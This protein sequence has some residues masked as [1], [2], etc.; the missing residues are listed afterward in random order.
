MTCLPTGLLEEKS[1][2]VDLNFGLF[3]SSVSTSAGLFWPM[4]VDLIFPGLRNA[5]ANGSKSAAL[6]AAASVFF[7]TV[8][9]VL[10]SKP[11]PL[12]EAPALGSKGLTVV[13]LFN[14]LLTLPA[15]VPLFSLGKTY[16]PP[17]SSAITPPAAWEGP[18]TGPPLANLGIEP[19]EALLPPKPPTGTVVGLVANVLARVLKPVLLIWIKLDNWFTLWVDEEFI[20]LKRFAIWVFILV[21]IWFV[22]FVAWTFCCAACAVACPVTV[23]AALPIF[24]KPPPERKPP[25]A[26]PSFRVPKPVNN[27]K[28]GSIVSTTLVIVFKILS[29]VESKPLNAPWK[30]SDSNNVLMSSLNDCLTLSIR[31]LIVCRPLSTSPSSPATAPLCAASKASLA[32]WNSAIAGNNL[33]ICLIPP[34]S[35]AIAL[36]VRASPCLINASS[37][38][39][40]WSNAGNIPINLPCASSKSTPNCFKKLIVDLLWILEKIV[41]KPAAIVSADSL[42]VDLTA[43]KIAVNSCNAWI[44]PLLS[45]A[46]WAKTPPVL[47]TTEIKSSASTANCLDTW[48]KEP[49]IASDW[50]ADN[51]NCPNA[52]INPSVVSVML[53]NVGAN[54]DF[55]N[56]A[57]IG[58]ISAALLPVCAI[59][60]EVSANWFALVPK[61]VAS[62]FIS[63]LRPDSAF[64]LAPVTWD[65]LT[66]S[67]SKDTAS[68]TAAENAL[69][70]S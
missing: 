2:R 44:V 45:P 49:K 27:G 52:A 61:D 5:P 38:V 3:F 68:F 46:A 12:T 30:P 48:F 11:L 6:L 55:A 34:S 37:F 32:F 39:D 31:L 1:K 20:E 64:T 29:V 40:N 22:W 8:K 59:I 33:P 18:Y 9:V 54:V 58:W 14:S 69:C 15:S 42:V 50:L 24:P 25:K 21:K 43:V 36:K 19:P 60:L 56:A 10:S 17:S 53:P 63:S 66:I 51:W 57:R 23:L 47:R 67:F 28:I 62:L 70:T 41:L 4:N 26:C 35:S 7:N 16:S 13:I 65:I